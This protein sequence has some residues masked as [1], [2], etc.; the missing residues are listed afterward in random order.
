MAWLLGVWAI[1]LPALAAAHDLEHALEDHDH[2]P[3][4]CACAAFADRDD[5]AL[6]PPLTRVLTPSERSFAVLEV[7]A[8]DLASLDLHAPQ[9][10]RAPPVR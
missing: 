7:V 10:I 1:L 4:L 6:P 5:D 3:V 9:A 2:A 8:K